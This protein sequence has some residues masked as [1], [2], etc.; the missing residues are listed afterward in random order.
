MSG[1]FSFICPR[2]NSGANERLILP[3]VTYRLYFH[4]VFSTKRRLPLLTQGLIADIRNTVQDL[5]IEIGFQAIA[6]GGYEDHLHLLLSMPPHM[7]LATVIKR[8]KG[9]TSREH[10]NLYWQ[11]GYYAES[12]SDSGVA[13]LTDYIQH[14]WQKHKL[15]ALE[16]A[17]FF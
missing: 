2:I 5:S 15:R 11:T 16:D 9:R 3:H 6:T 1:P 17:G 10:E 13:N 12:A 7:N 8:I 14:Q 4:V